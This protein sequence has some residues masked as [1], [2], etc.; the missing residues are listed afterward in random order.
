VKIIYVNFWCF[1]KL[2][3]NFKISNTIT[4]ILM[5]QNVCRAFYCI[6]HGK[7]DHCRAPKFPAHGKGHQPAHSSS[8]PK[9]IPHPAHGPISPSGPLQPQPL[10]DRWS[11]MW[12]TDIGNGHGW[13]LVTG[14]A[15][16][17]DQALQITH[18]R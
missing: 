9:Q 16:V 10:R 1:W 12:K 3:D 8:G 11:T 14:I 4:K 7:D 6:V 18:H 13:L 5:V 17:T 15:P 2:F